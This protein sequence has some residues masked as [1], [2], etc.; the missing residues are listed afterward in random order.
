MTDNSNIN[1]LIKHIEADSLLSPTHKRVLIKRV[2]VFPEDAE[3]YAADVELEAEH[4]AAEAR[5]EVIKERYADGKRAVDARILGLQCDKIRKQCDEVK[6]KLVVAENATQWAIFERNAAERR[7]THARTQCDQAQRERDEA[8]NEL[9][10]RVASGYDTAA[11]FL[12]ALVIV[13]DSLM[14]LTPRRVEQVRK[15]W[16]NPLTFPRVELLVEGRSW[17]LLDQVQVIDK[18]SEQAGAIADTGQLLGRRV[19][20]NDAPSNECR[21]TR[22]LKSWNDPTR[23]LVEVQVGD[24]TWYPLERLTFLDG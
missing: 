20:L 17:Y 19:K 21:I 14:S 8:R 10:Q 7:I 6:A 2:R 23:P 3:L 9:R 4:R 13:P 18:P 1:D 15:T 16:D 24:D 22:T 11:Q 12:G 5:E